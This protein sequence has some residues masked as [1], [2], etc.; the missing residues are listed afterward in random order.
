VRRAHERVESAAVECYVVSM[1]RGPSDLFAVLLMVQDAGVADRLDIVFFF[2]TVADFYAVLTTMERLFEN[3]AYG[4]TWRPAG[5][6]RPSW[7]ATAT[8]TRTAA[9]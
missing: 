7:W 2:E 9:T 8:P 6:C 5:A 3:P 4:A 1:T